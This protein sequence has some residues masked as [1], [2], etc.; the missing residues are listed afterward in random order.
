MP[1]MVMKLTRRRQYRSV[2]E[3]FA[4]VTEDAVL[5]G[6]QVQQVQPAQRVRQARG[7]Q[8]VQWGREELWGQWVQR[9]HVEQQVRLVHRGQQDQG[10][11]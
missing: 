3:T 7:E 9:V 8:V 4:D 2:Q 6:I 10:E 11:L 5:W 1:V